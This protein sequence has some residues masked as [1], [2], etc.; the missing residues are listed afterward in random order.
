MTRLKALKD[1]KDLEQVFDQIKEKLLL[2][3][4][5]FYLE[6]SYR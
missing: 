5:N 6:Q 1:N 2:D 4:K 3:W